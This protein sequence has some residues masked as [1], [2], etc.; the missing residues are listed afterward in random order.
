MRKKILLSVVGLIV[1]AA[2][3]A[4]LYTRPEPADTRFT[5][6]YSLDDGSVAFI[7]PREGK[8]LRYKLVNGESG[9]L[10]PTGNGQYEGGAGWAEREPVV[11]VIKFDMDAQGH[12]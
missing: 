10:W 5:G 8:V 1:V 3:G 9:A 6:A 7:A 2:F 4:Y 11:N 12:P